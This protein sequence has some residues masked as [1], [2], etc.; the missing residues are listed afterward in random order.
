MIPHRITDAARPTLSECK[1]RPQNGGAV[2]PIEGKK[3]CRTEAQRQQKHHQPDGAPPAEV[4]RGP[5][6]CHSVRLLQKPTISEIAR[7][8]QRESVT[9]EPSPRRRLVRPSVVPLSSESEL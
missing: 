3:R 7:P 8:N 5:D 4:P 1:R 9:R 6:S 2:Q